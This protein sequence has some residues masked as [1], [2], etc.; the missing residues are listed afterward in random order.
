MYFSLKINVI[1]YKLFS[2]RGNNNFAEISKNL[3]TDLKII[4]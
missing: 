4:L 3:N 2:L 1:I